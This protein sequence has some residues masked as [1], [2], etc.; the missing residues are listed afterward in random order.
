MK[1]EQICEY[2]Y[3]KKASSITHDKEYDRWLFTCDKCLTD[4]YWIG[5]NRIGEQDW[6]E[7][8]SKKGWVK[9]EQVLPRILWVKKFLTLK[10]GENGK[11]NQGKNSTKTVI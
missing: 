11:S 7:H 6:I 5:F 1:V 8:L 10:G 9:M 2:C 4:G 3:K